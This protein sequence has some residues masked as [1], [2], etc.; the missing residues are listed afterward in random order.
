MKSGCEHSWT[1][2]QVDDLYFECRGERGEMF[3]VA[4]HEMK[5]FIFMM[6]RQCQLDCVQPV[7]V[8]QQKEVKG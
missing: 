5:E 2:V 7:D 4:V 8:V 3:V 1:E 6:T